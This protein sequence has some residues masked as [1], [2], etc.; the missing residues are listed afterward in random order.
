MLRLTFFLIFY[1]PRIRRAKKKEARL[2]A[3]SRKRKLSSPP[4]RKSLKHRGP[5]YVEPEDKDDSDGDKSGPIPDKIVFEV[6][7][8]SLNL[9]RAHG[10]I[11]QCTRC[12]SKKIKCDIKPTRPCEGCT[13]AKVKCSLMPVDQ[14][15]KTIRTRLTA[16]EVFKF[17]MDQ[18]MGHT[19]KGK[20]SVRPSPD[21]EEDASPSTTLA[22][23]RRMTLS[24]PADSATSSLP[25]D[26]VDTPAPS[27]SSAALKPPATRKPPAATRSSGRSASSSVPT[28]DFC[29][30]VPRASAA[31]PS[32]SSQHPG[33][34]GSLHS[35]ASRPSHGEPSQTSDDRRNS[36]GMAL[37]EKRLDNLEY[38]FEQLGNRM[39]RIEEEMKALRRMVEDRMDES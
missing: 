11:R 23:L 37:V 26:P 22:P 13:L 7:F 1:K 30:D 2:P 34:Q 29:V 31:V 24:S 32:H 3:P 20:K 5:V 38:T 27:L 17:R 21:E 6:R 36:S 33:L 28:S 18:L 15:G 8:Y 25:E 16:D 12:K 39:G 14:H 10:G 9:F 35:Q 4:P 19:G